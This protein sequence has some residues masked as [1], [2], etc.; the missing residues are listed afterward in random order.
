MQPRPKRLRPG[1]RDG[2]T[3]DISCP[4]GKY[5]YPPKSNM[6]SL[7]STCDRGGKS[8]STRSISNLTRMKEAKIVVSLFTS[9]TEAPQPLTIWG[10][11]S[12]RCVYKPI[13]DQTAVALY[14]KVAHHIVDSGC[15]LMK[16]Y[17]HSDFCDGSSCIA[18]I[19]V[20]M[21]TVPSKWK[22]RLIVVKKKASGRALQ[23]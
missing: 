7:R 22:D 10:S 15:R 5:I 21:K 23:R 3:C 2:R 4:D 20:P 9:L 13:N 1:I 17:K 8:T 19:T 6:Y 11:E 18:R 14:C 16:I 12:N